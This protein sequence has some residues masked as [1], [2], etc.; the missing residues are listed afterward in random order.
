MQRLRLALLL[1]ATLPLY[2]ACAVA[3]AMAPTAAPAEAPLVTARTLT[4]TPALCKSIIVL[5]PPTF[6]LLGQPQGH[7][8]GWEQSWHVRAL[9]TQ[10]ST[11]LNE[12]GNNTGTTAPTLLGNLVQ[13]IKLRHASTGVSHAL[14]IA[15]KPAV[16]ARGMPDELGFEARRRDAATL[17]P[18][19]EFNYRDKQR[20]E[21]ALHRAVQALTR[22]LRTSGFV[23]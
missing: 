18:V 22:S 6:Y 7:A 1:A 19:W 11:A 13:E 3:P 21:G 8:P 12:A 15:T 16:S 20:A 9:L 4:P 23:R 14:V 2:V 5:S 17:N 10:V